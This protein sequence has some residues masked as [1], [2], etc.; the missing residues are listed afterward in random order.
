MKN[1]GPCK[2]HTILNTKLSTLI[3]T[4]YIMKKIINFVNFFDT[5]C[6]S[7]KQKNMQGFYDL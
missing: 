1:S 4:A 2:K 3:L 6:E 7:F 5:N